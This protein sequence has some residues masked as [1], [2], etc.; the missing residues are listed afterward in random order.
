MTIFNSALSHCRRKQQ[1]IQSI[2]PDW[3]G[4]NMASALQYL[5]NRLHE[6]QSRLFL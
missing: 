5:L 1:A 2:S 3:S 4:T 6:A